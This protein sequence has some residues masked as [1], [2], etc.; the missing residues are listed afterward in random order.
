MKMYTGIPI[1]MRCKPQ[2]FWSSQAVTVKYDSIQSS[3]VWTE[4]MGQAKGNDLA[5][6]KRRRR[7]F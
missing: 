2:R 3:D 1:G 6:Q 4:M 5:S 7:R